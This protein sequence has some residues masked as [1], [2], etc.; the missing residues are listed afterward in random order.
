MTIRPDPLARFRALFN[1]LPSERVPDL[2]GIYSENIDFRD[3]FVSVTGRQ[4]L[5][6]Y[7]TSAYANVISCR[8]DFDTSLSDGDDASLAWTMYLR[9]HR[10]Q[11]GREIMVEGIS[12][13]HLQEGLITRHRDY[14]DAGQLLYENVPLLGRAVRW[15]RRH[16][17]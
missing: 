9:H 4:A 3:P 7:L 2:S 1:S 6:D 5:T 13:L 15:L 8:F 11:G 14:F 12:L 17:A 10:L 16:A